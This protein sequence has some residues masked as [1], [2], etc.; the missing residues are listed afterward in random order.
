MG[1]QGSSGLSWQGAAGRQLGSEGYEFG[2]VTRSVTRRLSEIN[3]QSASGRKSGSYS[4]HFGDIS[5][6]LTLAVSVEVGNLLTPGQSRQ[7]SSSGFS[8]DLGDIWKLF[9]KQMLACGRQAVSDGL[10]PRADIEAQEPYL[11]LGLPGL[12]LLEVVLRS[13][14]APEGSLQLA[15]GEL[16]SVETLPCCTS[17]GAP[18][19]G[20]PELFSAL[21]AARAA[22]R[23]SPDS[24]SS[25]GSSSS[26]SA[27]AEADLSLLRRC[28]LFAGLPPGDG[29]EDLFQTEERGKVMKAASLFQ[30]VATDISQLPFFRA[31]A[32]QTLE[33]ILKP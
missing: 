4:Y 32:L 18:E 16:L 29:V 19:L 14:T 28:V 2:D 3:W 13:L 27:F 23:S 26:A 1:G 15:S 21:L 9:F 25:C 30:A 6:A 7:A 20:A 17:D 24:S 31:K 33:D 10:I 22:M 12:C 8:G 5:R 11:F